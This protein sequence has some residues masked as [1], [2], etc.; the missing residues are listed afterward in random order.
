MRYMFLILRPFKACNRQPKNQ[1]QTT[2]LTFFSVGI[3]HDQKATLL[4]NEHAARNSGVCNEQP[5]Q[6]EDRRLSS[7]EAA[8]QERASPWETAGKAG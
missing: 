1:A 5:Q 2:D 3:A 8:D 7:Q 4:S 6:A